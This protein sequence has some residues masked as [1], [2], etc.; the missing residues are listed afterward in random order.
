MHREKASTTTAAASTTTLPTCRSKFPFLCLSS[1]GLSGRFRAIRSFRL[2]FATT[3]LVVN[4]LTAYIFHA[5]CRYS[6]FHLASSNSL[7]SFRKLHGF[8]CHWK[9]G[10]CCN[11][12]EQCWHWRKQ[13]L[14]CRRCQRLT[15][16]FPNGSELPTSNAVG[17][18]MQYSYTIRNSKL[19]KLDENFPLDTLPRK[20]RS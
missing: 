13:C 7:Y 10:L 12:T 17:G 6:V 4:H 3:P 18:T 16:Q 11:V 1:N 20:S 15:Q 2:L 19:Y 8:V 14:Y 9:N 5:T